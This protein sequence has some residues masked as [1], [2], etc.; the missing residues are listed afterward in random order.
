[1]PPFEKGGIKNPFF[2]KKNAFLALPFLQKCFKNVALVFCALQK[3]VFALILVQTHCKNR[4]FVSPPN[5][6]LTL[7]VISILTIYKKLR[8]SLNKRFSLNVFQ[9]VF[10]LKKPGE[11]R[12]FED[13]SE[14]LRFVLFFSSHRLIRLQNIRFS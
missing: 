6:N 1:M 13:C 14:N 8:M 10:S 7:C 3:P 11:N 5:L 2:S 4:R 9:G 12:L